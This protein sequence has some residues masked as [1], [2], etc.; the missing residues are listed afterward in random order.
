MSKTK[1]PESKRLSAEQKALSEI[2]AAFN[3]IMDYVSRRLT[4]KALQEKC[5]ALKQSSAL[6]QG[7]KRLIDKITDKST[8]NQA[9]KAVT[10]LLAG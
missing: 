10:S 4:F 5:V 3:A 6:L 9:R 7:V 8:A 1:R 2:Q